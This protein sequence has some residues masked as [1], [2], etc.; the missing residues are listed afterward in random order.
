MNAAPPDNEPDR[1]RILREYE[2]LDTGPERAFDDIVHLAA[3]VCHTPIAVIT[4]LDETR[5]W[6]KACHGL[7]FSDHPRNPSFC[8]HALVTPH[9]LEV[10]DATLDARFAHH[11]LVTGAPHLRFYAGTRLLSPEGAAL[12]TLAVL[13]IAP[14]HLTPAQLDALQVLNRQVMT[15]LELRRHL[16]QQQQLMVAAEASLET[17]TAY[18][19]AMFDAALD[20]I[21]MMDSTGRVISFNP[22][23]EQL[24]GYDREEARGRLMADLIMPPAD[25]DRHAQGLARHLLTGESIL[26]GQRTE[27]TAMRRDGTVFP[28]E[29]AI[30][31][32]RGDDPPVFTGFIRDITERTRATRELQ[33]SERRYLQQRRAMAT[34]I[35]DERLYHGDLSNALRQVTRTVA[36]TLDV[37]RV[38]VWRHEDDKSVIRCLD[39][40]EQ[41]DDRHSSG[42]VLGAAATP[43][44]FAALAEVEVI[45]AHDARRDPRTREF[46]EGYLVPLGITSMLDAPVHLD[47]E[48]HGVLCLEHVGPLR[49]WTPEDQTFAVAAANL[50]SLALEGHQRRQ[51]QEAL[52]T[53]ATILTAVTESL[54]AYVERDDWTEA[55]SRLLRCALALTDSEY[56]FVGVV[57]E[58][59]ELR[60]PAHEGLV[61]DDAGSL[62]GQAVTSGTVVIA[63]HLEPD[64]RV[65]GQPAGR[66]AVTSLLAVPIRGRDQITGL[67]ALANRHSGYGGEEQRRIET[68]VQQVGG[69][70]ESYR[71]RERAHVQDRERQEVEAALQASDERLRIVARAT[72][73]TVWD[74]DLVT[75]RFYVPDGFRKL[76]G[77][78]HQ[79]IPTSIESWH[80]RVHPDDAERLSAGLRAA[81]D[82]GAH[83]WSDEYRCHRLDG[84]Y[85][86][87]FDRGYVLRDDEGRP[88][89]MIGALMD[90][91]ERRQLEAQFRQSQKLEAVGQLAGGVAHDF[92]N[93]LTA[94]QGH[95]SL[96]LAEGQQTAD[97]TDSIRQIL[98][99]AERAAGL[100]RQLLAFSRKQ[101]LQTTD[102]DINDVVAGMVRLLQRILGED[103][104]LQI[105]PA[106]SPAIV[107]A[108]VSMLEQVILNLAVNARDAMPD[109]G[110]LTLTTT[111]ERIDDGAVPEHADARPG[112]FVCLSTTDSG[113]GIPIDVLPHIFEPFFTT[114]GVER[115]TGLGLA[116]VYGI[117]KQ[118]GGWVTLR[119]VVGEG[120]TFD[121]YLPAVAEPAKARPASGVRRSEAR[122]RE[123]VLIVEDEAS[124]RRLARLILQRRGYT[125]LEAES[126][127][128]ALAVWQAHLGR[129]DLVLTDMVMPGGVSG[130]HLA[131]TLLEA[132]P[133]LRVIVTSGYSVDLAGKDLAHTDG[134]SL[135]RKPYSSDGLAD[136]VRASLDGH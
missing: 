117:V 90:I 34:L 13:D 80:G 29:L 37:A 94:I 5:Q 39:L 59:P 7:T 57:V 62:F 76:L 63:N 66:P 114:K 64:P 73:D 103:I 21:V 135:L 42:T 41:P 24:F 72:N 89:R 95:A 79:P 96:L 125:V 55:F 132:R 31:R 124:V 93:I 40:F 26:L 38:S 84:T 74:W 2:I 4:F 106:A 133:D 78:E 102:V 98:E 6:F 25:R 118:H 99:A 48:L 10:P 30:H 28:V 75:N 15:Q 116:T 9:V 70:C 19:R 1:L 123:T 110:H 134:V 61:W 120:T 88:V 107:R 127:P 131:S 54:A 83:V 111:V 20:A 68:L 109:G 11:A 60:V 16:A 23:A 122:G 129:I 87:V 27:V 67:I 71:Q 100:T 12:G 65:S 49:E 119:S 113:C 69:L 97:A 86:T 101:V 136:A 121:V 14:R 128:A 44:Y 45:P 91:S 22:A 92:N 85:A 58:G 108:D 53:Q 82:G 104:A 32:L 81:I 112:L 36:L 43:A 51:A 33:A 18:H 47:G 126:G 35:Q 52:L 3:H 130:L 105:R 115:G 77:D 17:A 46:T 56:G 8:A 50:V